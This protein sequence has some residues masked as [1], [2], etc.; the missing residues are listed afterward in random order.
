MSINPRNLGLG[1]LVTHFLEGDNPLHAHITP[2]YQT[3]TYSFPDVQTSADTFDGKVDGF[4]YSRSDNPNARQ[5]AEKIAMLEG[6]DLLKEASQS[7]VKDIVRG[8]AFSSGMAAISTAVLSL[9]KAGSTIISQRVLYG[10][11]YNL[12]KKINVDNRFQA[13]LWAAQNL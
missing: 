6:F 2:L 13:A 8:K 12:F 1:T 9:A 7:D 11:T 5:L 4:I 10:N 3:S